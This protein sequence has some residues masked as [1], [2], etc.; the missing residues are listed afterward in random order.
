MTSTTTEPAKIDTTSERLKSFIERIERLL[1][2][3]KGISDDIKEVF[4]EAKG[5]GFEPAIMKQVIKIRA[6]PASER[7]EYE[8]VLETYLAALGISAHA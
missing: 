6:M 1:D 8:A 7:Q 3:K 4:S 5:H 2:E